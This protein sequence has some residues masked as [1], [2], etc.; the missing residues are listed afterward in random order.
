MI[1]RSLV[2]RRISVDIRGKI[3]TGYKHPTSGLPVKTD[4]FVIDK[5][6]ELRSDYAEKPNK[7]II[8]FPDDDI[9]EVMD[10]D[11]VKWGRKEGQ[12]RGFKTR[13]CTGK[14]CTI[15]TDCEIGGETFKAGD[16]VPCVCRALLD[17]EKDKKQ[18]CRADMYLRAYIFCPSVG[19]PD[20][21]LCYIF[22]SHSTNSADAILNVLE[23]VKRL[24]IDDNNPNGR[25]VGIPFLLSVKM[26][27]DI[28]KSYPIWHLQPIGTVT[29]IREWA[30][31]ARK[32]NLILPKNE[33]KLETTEQG[34]YE[35]INEDDGDKEETILARNSD[36]VP[37]VADIPAS[38]AKDTSKDMDAEK[39]KIA[40]AHMGVLL[41][42][43]RQLPQDRRV[44]ITWKNEKQSEFE[45]LPPE[46]FRNVFNALNDKMQSIK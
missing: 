18:I 42:E 29:K 46:M 21:P 22:E 33:L 10:Y 20:N 19:R 11:F 23:D 9:E 4:Y 40:D 12:E 1:D 38:P 26:I 17:P 39:M 30:L 36:T 44:V 27:Q 31:D 35:V 45:S 14:T 16:V 3:K 5:F 28:K 37:F 34:G 43:L 25:L 8:F 24:T 32:S 7:L 13:S 15:R 6:P 2:K 41:D